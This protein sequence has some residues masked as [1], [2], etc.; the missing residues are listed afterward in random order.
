MNDQ[1]KLN[2]AIT[3]F[4]SIKEVIEAMKLETNQSAEEQEKLFQ[5][6]ERIIDYT[7]IE[8]NG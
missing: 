8:I 4:R 5:N 3:A 6:I 1:A 2:E 7:L